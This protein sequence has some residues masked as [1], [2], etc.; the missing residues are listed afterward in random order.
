MKRRIESFHAVRWWVALTV[1]CSALAA[2]SASA[3]PTHSVTVPTQA[4]P[5]QGKEVKELLDTPFVRLVSITLHNGTVLAEHSA[6]VA[7]TIQALSGSG[8]V[9]TGEKKERVAPGQMLL[10]GPNAVHEVTPDGKSDLV[11]LVHFLKMAPS[12]AEKAPTHDHGH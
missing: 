4:G 5:G 12:A 8:V 2:P 11:L 3:C 10:I 7:V 9:R 1:T 6:P